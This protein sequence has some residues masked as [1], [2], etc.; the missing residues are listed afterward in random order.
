[1]AALRRPR[2]PPWASPG[3]PR[4]TP[5]RP[6]RAAHGPSG[7]GVP[8]RA[9]GIEAVSPPDPGLGGAPGVEHRGGRGP[10]GPPTGGVGGSPT[11]LVRPAA[12]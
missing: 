1:M 4:P 9:V 12:T 8:L 11:Q 5:S 6:C 2:G 10:G 3:S 7:Q